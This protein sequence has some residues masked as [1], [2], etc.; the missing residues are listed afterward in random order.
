M[1]WPEVTRLVPP[2]P[3]AL[4]NLQPVGSGYLDLRLPWLTL[5][6]GGPEPGYLTR[7]GPITPVQARYLALLAASDPAVEWRIV[8]TDSSSRAIGVA[9]VRPSRV[10]AGPA[11]ASPGK[12]SSLLHR[13]TVILNADELSAADS[14]IQHRDENIAKVG[15]AIITAARLA[16]DQ[17]TERAAAD[18]AVGGC[19]HTQASPAYQVPA[20][21]REF[22]NLR[23]LTC[24][25][26]TC[27]QPAW[28]CDTDHTT[29]YDQ[30]GPTCLC[31]LGALCRYHHK[32]KQHRRWNLDQPAPGSFIWTT[33]T[34]RAYN[35]QP[36]KQAA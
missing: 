14:G 1:P 21:L 25:F 4:K 26:P 11:R 13:V 34:G 15:T 28:R 30:D 7:L 18:A 27:R 29:P 22:I 35:V 17:A 2:G 9:R 6:H 10:L 24:R 20:R 36:D 32:L 23:D 19:A 3:T 5:I 31:N 33:P 12:S 8:I 16:V